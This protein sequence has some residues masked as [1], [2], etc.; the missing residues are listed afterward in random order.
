MIQEEDILEE[1]DEVS[2]FEDVYS[3]PW[4]MFDGSSLNGGCED[5]KVLVLVV[6]CNGFGDIVFGIKF[7]NYLRQWYNCDLTIG[8]T[9]PESFV[10]L[11][12]DAKNLITLKKANSKVRGDCRRFRNLEIQS[13]KKTPEFDLIF[14]APLQEGYDVNRSDVRALFPY[15]TRLNT[16][17]LSEYNDSTFKNFDFD[18][19][20]GS[21]RM[22][23]LLT[24]IKKLKKLPQMKCKYVV[25]YL[26]ETIVNA[27]PCF[28]NFLQMIAQKYSSKYS[29]FDIVAPPWVGEKLLTR[30]YQNKVMRLIAPY[31][32]I[33]RIINKDKSVVTMNLKVKKHE[34]VQTGKT[35]TIRCDVLPLANMDM[36]RLMRY[37]ERDILLT[38]DQSITD[39]FSLNK[40]A[41]IFY[42]IAGWK[43]NLAKNLEKEMPQHYFKRKRTSC[44]TVKAIHLKSNFKK[45]VKKWDFRKLAR[46]KMDAI[47]LAALERQDNPVVQDFEET[48]LQSRSLI[49]LRN[50]YS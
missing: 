48:V 18:T 44:G 43:E 20:V 47:F 28:F 21:G 29:H 40:S 31:Y 45:F 10:T 19:G 12:E 5:L 25:T 4:R 15:S 37:S 1:L 46:G 27:V 7:S 2:R 11:G 23:L 50:K 24:D 41:N 9:K 38:G 14:V 39:F 17:F 35:L 32:P 26:A 49:S 16:F 8:T 30:N 3:I 36:L 22:G 34:V 6:P 33:V 42:Q 13:R